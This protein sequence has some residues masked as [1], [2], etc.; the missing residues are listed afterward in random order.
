MERLYSGKMGQKTR[1]MQDDS[2]TRTESYTLSFTRNPQCI[3]GVS[4]SGV[5]NVGDFSKTFFREER[6]NDFLQDM[7]N[8]KHRTSLRQTSVL[9]R[10]NIGTFPQRCPMFFVSETGAY[11]MIYTRHKICIL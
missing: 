7:G 10:Q 11:T 6:R 1:K 3:K 4:R 5:G 9:S 8:R 2:Y